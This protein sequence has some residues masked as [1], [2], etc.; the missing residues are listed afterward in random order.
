MHAGLGLEGAEQKN[1]V[2]P[3]SKSR[4]SEKSVN[5]ASSSLDPFSARSETSM[6]RLKSSLFIPAQLHDARS[7]A[8]TQRTGSP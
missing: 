6:P 2:R 7:P 5:A 1:R 4:P 8:L 3:Y